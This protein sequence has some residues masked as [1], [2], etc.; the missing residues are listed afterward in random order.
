VWRRWYVAGP[1][2]AALAITAGIIW[3]KHAQP[4]CDRCVMIGG[5]DCTAT[6]K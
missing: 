3:Y 6:C 1:I 4:G 2:A 5:V